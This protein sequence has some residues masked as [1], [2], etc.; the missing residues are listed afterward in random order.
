M[1]QRPRAKRGRMAVEG[2]LTPT[3]EQ[4]W[5][6]LSTTPSLL[7]HGFHI[8]HHLYNAWQA[9]GIIPPF[10]ARVRVFHPHA[11]F[12]FGAFEVAD[13][14]AILPIASPGRYQKRKVDGNYGGSKS[15]TPDGRAWQNR[16]PCGH[17][18][19]AGLGNR[20]KARGCDKRHHGQINHYP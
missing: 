4:R 16:N 19:S 14:E 15:Y 8:I 5:A 13:G 11:R 6:P 9:C 3:T 2:A 7:P 20:H 1:F 18:R 17:T 12:L 10:S